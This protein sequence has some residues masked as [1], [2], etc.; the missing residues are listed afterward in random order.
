MLALDS[1]FCLQYGIPSDPL[2]S[3]VSTNT[4][5]ATETHYVYFLA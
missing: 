1:H 3:I 2:V 5:P 4:V